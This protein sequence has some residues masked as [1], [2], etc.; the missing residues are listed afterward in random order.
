MYSRGNNKLR[1]DRNERGCSKSFEPYRIPHLESTEENLVNVYLE[2][3]SHGIIKEVDATEVQNL[4]N[5]GEITIK[6]ICNDL[7]SI[8]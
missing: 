1:G 3:V 4:I 7:F 2:Y 6:R 5:S 8:R